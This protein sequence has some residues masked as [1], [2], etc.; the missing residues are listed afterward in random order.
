[1]VGNFTA[2]GSVVRGDGNP[3][4][5]HDGNLSIDLDKTGATYG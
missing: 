1:L 3:I 2:G 5:F 4:E